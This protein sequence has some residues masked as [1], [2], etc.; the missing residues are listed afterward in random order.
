MPFGK[1]KNIS[2]I[3]VGIQNIKAKAKIQDLE[4]D[5]TKTLPQEIKE[6]QRN[7]INNYNGLLIKGSFGQ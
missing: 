3:S 6:K 5:F 2:N 1:F 7:L 4:L